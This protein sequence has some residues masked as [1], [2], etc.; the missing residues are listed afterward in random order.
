MRTALL[1]VILAAGLRAQIFSPTSGSSNTIDVTKAPYNAKCDGVTDDRLAFQKAINQGN[2]NW[3]RTGKLWTVTMPGKTCIMGSSV[4][5]D[6]L[7]QRNLDLLSGVTIQGVPGQSKLLQTAAGRVS[8]RGSFNAVINVGVFFPTFKAYTNTYYNLA[9][10]PILGSNTITLANAAD[11]A[12]FNTGDY[13]AYY[14]RAS[15]PPDDVQPQNESQLSNVDKAI[16]VLTL[17]NP[18]GIPFVANGFTPA[19]VNVSAHGLGN[20][21]SGINGVIVQGQNPI[22]ITE[23]F[24]FTAKN[25]QFLTD[26][27]V[28]NGLKTPEMNT[29][30]NSTFDS[31]VWD[32]INGSLFTISAEL[33]QRGSSY[34][35]WTNN[36]F[37][38][39][40]S[41]FGSWGEGEF[42]A[43]NTFSGNHIYA[44]A[45]PGG[46]FCA[47][48]PMGNNIAFTGNDVHV[49]GNWNQVNGAII[50][51]YEDAVVV[52]PPSRTNNY[53]NGVAGVT[54]SNNTIDCTADGNGCITVFGNGTRVV[55]NTINVS[56]GSSA[57]GVLVNGTFCVGGCAQ[58][59]QVNGN[60]IKTAGGVGVSLSVGKADSWT[61]NGN[62]FTNSAGRGTGILVQGGSPSNGGSGCQIQ[63]NTSGTGIETVLSRIPMNHP[64][65]TASNNH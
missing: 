36:T 28:A 3:R 4:N 6:S 50:C 7:V 2:S 22:F 23:A 51:D 38:S 42:N 63:N 16:G 56:A 44:N 18:V 61:I 12:H 5:P 24:Y 35:T 13:V 47:F 57:N 31:N 39:P 8:R 64:A 25:C 20:Y 65:C 55:G 62:T 26:A 48:E 58:T 45:V 19:V 49:T 40:T 21:H 52:N 59:T 32:T 54:I 1:F 15:Q 27:S 34:D 41:G 43:G 37:G 30:I 33:P 11:A 10:N 14:Y 29:V 53:Y 17:V 46:P 60:N 9:T